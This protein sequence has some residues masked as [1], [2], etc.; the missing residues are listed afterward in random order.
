MNLIIVGAGKVGQT[1]VENF[2][3]E[4]HDIVVVDV[5]S[6]TVSNVVNRYDVR[7]VVGS[8]IE[9]DVLIQAGIE[10]ADFFIACT[11][12]DEINILCSVLGKKLGA[13]HTV[14]RVRDPEY[15]KEMG[16]MR[17]IL[18]IDMAFNPE[19]RT[20]S[21]IAKILKFPSAKRVE[22]FAGGKATMIEFDILE[23]NPVIGKNLID[24]SKEYGKVLFATVFRGDKS[25]IPHGD[26]VLQ[27]GDSVNLIASDAELNSFTKKLKIFKPRAKAVF[28]I[29]GGKICYYLAKELL[30]SGVSVKILEKDKQRAEELS[31]LLPQANVI[32]G[33]ATE[34]ELLVEEGI[35]RC[36][37]SIALTG[38]DE[39]NVIISMFAKE[40]GVHKVVTKIDRP[41]IVKM[42]KSFGLDSVLSP[43]EVIANHIIR[44][45]RSST[46]T[47]DGEINTLY[48]L[49]ESVEAIEFT[50]SENFESKDVPLKNLKIKGDALIVGIVRNGEF[51]LPSGESVLTTGDRVIVV[52][53]Q[54]QTNGLVQIIN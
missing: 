50:V 3:N 49:N 6:E 21:D 46:A 18:G 32:L 31:E 41:S 29:G 36:D 43:R 12:Q 27:K 19:F 25:Y 51:I 37:A 13:K 28:I 15:F 38:M 34:Q 10:S 52:T 23:G 20:A 53:A 16:N 40:T 48:K 8:G 17:E 42:A 14:A 45:V 30:S 11:S 35:T 7:G 26:F 5:N 54:R 47:V 4:N 22:S 1:L 2:I 9:R 39:E 44:F 24:I 33:D